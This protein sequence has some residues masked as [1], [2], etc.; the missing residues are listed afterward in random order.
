ENP[1]PTPGMSNGV[2]VA[3][4]WPTATVTSV[5]PNPI[6]A[7]S[8]MTLTFTGSNFLSPPDQVFLKD[9][10]GTATCNSFE[11]VLPMTSTHMTYQIPPCVT[12]VAGDYQ[13]EIISN[14]GGLTYSFPNPFI[15]HARPSAAGV[16]SID[17]GVPQRWPLPDVEP[18]TTVALTMA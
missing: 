3:V 1:A 6:I 17:L 9:P 15:L 4:T 11:L 8:N 16:S 18:F 13:V 14:T 5:S 10:S 12:P 7:A 2:A